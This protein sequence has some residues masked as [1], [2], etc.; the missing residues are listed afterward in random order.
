MAYR[1]ILIKNALVLA[2]MDDS[3]REIKGGDIY[4]EGPEIR[5]IGK[6]LK[7]KA[8]TVIDAKNCVVLPGF[9]NTH[10]HLYQTL[11]RNLPAVQDSKLFDWLVYLYEVW[12]HVTP[13]GVNVSAQVGLGEL[14]LTGCTT[15]SDHFYL[16]PG[17]MSAELIDR[18]IEGAA[19]VGRRLHRCRG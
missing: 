9:V 13:E 4:I 2:T 12:R 8:D 14:L 1:S 16:F 6:G 17:G 11:T 3:G 7:M 5:K 18:E 10:H 15:S 19:A